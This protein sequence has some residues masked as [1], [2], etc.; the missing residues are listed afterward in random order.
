MWDFL[1]FDFPRLT[2]R[3]SLDYTESA[4]A[5]QAFARADVFSALT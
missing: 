2:G 3:R 5:D 1:T 4:R